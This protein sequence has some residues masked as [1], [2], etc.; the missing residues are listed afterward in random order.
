VTDGR[1]EREELLEKV[2]MFSALNKKEM[3]KIA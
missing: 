2:S 1:K 3:T